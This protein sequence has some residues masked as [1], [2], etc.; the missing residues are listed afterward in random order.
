M[1]FL[2]TLFRRPPPAAPASDADA[3][4]LETVRT[5]PYTLDYSG[6][7]TKEDIFYCFRLLL[8]RTP[9]PEEWPG[10]SSRVGQKLDAV[11]ETF[12]NSGEFKDR[13]L[14]K[15]KMPDGLTCGDNGRF[16]IW[17]DGNDPVIGG[18][19][20]RG[21]YER[22]VAATI[23]AS[24]APGNSFVDIGA[25]I[26]YFALL[27]RTIVGPGGQVV[28]IEPNDYNVKL[29]EQ[30]IQANG[31]DNISV[32]QV[33]VSDRIET[34][35]LNATTGNG[36][37]SALGQTQDKIQNA[38][39]VASL[40]LDALLALRTQP[41]RLIKIDVE[42]YENIALRGAEALLRADRPDIIF[43]F[44]PTNL[45]GASGPG[46]LNWLA[47][48]G[49]TFRSLRAGAETDFSPAADRIMQDF[50]RAGSDHIDVHA[51]AT[52]RAA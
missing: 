10:H 39:T 24:L 4:W 22:D 15:V 25:N 48:L 34:L 12:V 46:F 36:S 13:D 17:A 27:A 21:E 49:Y 47:G 32:A 26:G 23:E 33:A 29:I 40:P 42:G 52:T 16:R 8:A 44:S 11:V 7:T 37:T 31:F 28:A 3:R 51:Q 2:K 41:V 38:R 50:E 14:L 35:S 6:I 1:T 45:E 30:S 9:N 43:E 18:P 20:L 5:A 19:S